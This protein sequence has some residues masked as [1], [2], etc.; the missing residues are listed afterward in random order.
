MTLLIPAV[1]SAGAWIWLGEDLNMTQIVAMGFVFLALG[2]IVGK[3]GGFG[4][5]PRPLRR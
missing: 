2:G 3:Q 4:S 1:S 5:R